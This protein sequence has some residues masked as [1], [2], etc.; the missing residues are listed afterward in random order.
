MTSWKQA[1]AIAAAML[2]FASSPIM[3]AVGARADPGES[4]LDAAASAPPGAALAFS[5]S[6]ENGSIRLAWQAPSDDGGAPIIGYKVFRG[7]GN[8]AGTM[9]A[10]VCG[11][12]YEDASAAD[13]VE[14]H[15]WVCAYNQAGD[16]AMTP[17]AVGSVGI[18]S[19]PMPLLPAILIVI[20]I[21]G[22]FM[23][24]MYVRRR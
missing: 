11:T 19:G 3:F 21:V 4:F 7:S 20:A 2:L 15:Y 18:T 16:G 6:E 14:Y 24:Y 5:A 10:I 17:E 9:L 1:C 23:A 13:G 8:D 22:I 12:S